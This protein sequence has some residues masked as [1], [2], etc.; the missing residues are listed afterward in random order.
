[1]RGQRVTFRRFGAIAFAVAVLCCIARPDA[2]AQQLQV[3]DKAPLGDVAG[4]ID[5]LAV[6]VAQRRLFVAELGN[7]SVGIVAIDSRKVVHRI[8]GLK[9]PQGLSYLTSADLLSVANGGDGSVR[10]FNATS[11]EPAGQIQLGGDADNIRLD[12]S[13]RTFVGYGNGAIA[14]IDTATKR[15]LSDIPLKAHPEGFQLSRSSPNIFVNVPDKREIAVLD[16]DAGKQIASWRL[17]KGANFPMALNEESQHVI[18]AFRNPPTLEVFSARDGSS[19]ASVDSCGD[20]DDVFFDA[21]RHRVYMS[22]G[23]G[24]VDVFDAETGYRRVARVRTIAGART[25]LFV[26]ELDRLFVAARAAWREG[27]SIWILRPVP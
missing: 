21:R 26:P 23:S 17:N 20:S 13:G 14:V 19:I 1:M 18:V 4:R 2:L 10:F 16:R 8:T 22:C 27:A 9:T 24:F 6:D 12:A 25:S 5:H 7:N 11:F 3:E 15:K